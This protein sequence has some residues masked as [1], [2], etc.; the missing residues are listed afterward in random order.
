MA[1]KV[2]IILLNWNGWIDTIE[3]L[4]S[5]FRSNYPNYQVIVCD[6]NSQDRSL[7]HIQAWAEGRLDVSLPT[8]NSLRRLSFPPVPK[9]IPYI[10]WR[11]TNAENNITADDVNR[12]LVLIQINANL[13]FAGGCNVGLRYIASKNDFNYV[14]LLNNDTVIESSALD[15]L[16]QRMREKPRAGLCGSTIIYYHDPTRIQ[17]LGGFKY[18]KWLGTSKQIGNLDAWKESVDQ[19]QIEKQMFGIQGA[20]ILV[21]NEFIKTIGLMSEDYFLYFEEQDWAMRAKEKFELAFSS[22]SVVYH[23]EGT[24]T[25]GRSFQKKKSLLSDYFSSRSRLLFTKKFF[26]WA[27]PTVYLGIILAVLKRIFYFD[28]LNALMLV[29]ALLKYSDR[30]HSAS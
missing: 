20:S 13:G 14:W 26:P 27:L 17:A 16:V 12:S 10:L 22:L 11:Y 29:K 28:F 9:P 8:T 25:G 23:K 24:S 18:N 1:K 2:Y 3:C 7:E 21:S 19:E 30:S 15:Y 5:V 6:N 4:E